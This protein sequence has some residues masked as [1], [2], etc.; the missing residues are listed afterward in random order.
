MSCRGLHA[1]QNIRR[2]KNSP[3]YAFRNL[4]ART[5]FE[6]CL[7]DTSLRVAVAY[8]AG[9]VKAPAIPFP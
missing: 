9:K 7:V 2:Y 8:L 1:N 3:K 5:R 6:Y 4:F